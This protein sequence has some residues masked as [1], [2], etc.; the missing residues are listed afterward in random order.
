MRNLSLRKKRTL[1][2][3]DR[4]TW[5]DVVKTATPLHDD[6][7]LL[8]PS[9]ASVDDGEEDWL[10]DQAL[11]WPLPA[12]GSPSSLRLGPELKVGDHANVDKRTLERLRLGKMEI[13]SRLDLHGLTQT[14][15]HH[16]LESF[17]LQ[18]RA[19]GRRCV[20]VIT[21]KGYRGEGVLK[22]EVPRWLNEKHLRSHVVSIHY[23]QLR[24]GGS[25]ALYVLLRRH[26]E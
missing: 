1:T 2:D 8:L 3:A 10:T 6:Y 26:R 15:A 7:S 21:G 25:G 24:H 22:N 13:E 20:L 18:Q 4:Q 16:R 9:G 5:G 23:A 19:L 17:I 14:E 11:Y 12:D